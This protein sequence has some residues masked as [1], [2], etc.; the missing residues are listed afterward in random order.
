[1]GNL[2]LA[3]ARLDKYISLKNILPATNTHGVL[4][5]KELPKLLVNHTGDGQILVG[6]KIANTN[7]V[8]KSRKKKRFC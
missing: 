2:E 1:M 5:N 8:F 3:N 6:T 7:C 4:V